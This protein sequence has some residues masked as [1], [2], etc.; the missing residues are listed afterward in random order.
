V[1]RSGQFDEA[2]RILTGVAAVP[3]FSVVIAL[4]Q[5]HHK[6]IV[7][8]VFATLKKGTTGLGADLNL[9]QTVYGCGQPNK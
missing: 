7:A 4:L 8:D 5:P 6:Q 2:V 1:V 3:R 9:L